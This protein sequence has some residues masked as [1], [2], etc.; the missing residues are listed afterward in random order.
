MPRSLF[1]IRTCLIL[2][3]VFSLQYIYA[4]S[5]DK[6][7]ILIISSYHSDTKYTYDNINDFINKYQRLGG[8]YAVGIENMYCTSLRDAATWKKALE[9]LLEKHSAPKLIILLGAEAWFS[10]FSLEEEKYKQ[11][12]VFCA[13]SY[14]YAACLEDCTL[15]TPAA[16]GT[17]DFLTL[18]EPFNV[19]A[20]YTYDY[21]VDLDIDLIRAFYPETKNIAFLS[22]NTYNGISHLRLMQSEMK[23]YPDLKLIPIDGR[24]ETLE[25][26]KEI[27]HNLPE[28]TVM[29]LGI[30]RIDKNDI[31]YMNNAVYS[32][33]SA[34]PDL[35]VFS[36]T[37]TGIGYWAIGG[38]VPVYEEIGEKLAV[39]A[40]RLLDQK[41]NE[42]KVVRI[43]D[44]EYK[45]DAKKLAEL[46][47]SKKMLPANSVLVNEEVSFWVRYR[48]PIIMVLLIIVLLSAGFITTFYYYLRVR[49]L[50]GHLAESEKQLR[51]DKEALEHSE[52]ELRIAKEKAEEANKMKSA[53]VSN[54]SHEIRTPLNAIVGFS[55]I[56]ASEVEGSDETKEYVRIIKQNSDL[57]LQLIN[58]IL[59]LSRLESGQIKLSLEKCDIIPYCRSIIKIV[60]QSKS[61]KV[62][63]LFS[64]PVEQLYLTT[65]TNRLQQII[66]N[67][68]T[69]AIKFTNDG[70]IELSVQLEK[71]SNRAIFS[72][73]DTGCGIPLE[74]QAKVFE[75]FVKVNEFIQGT[76]LGLSIC[77]LTVEKL[78]G[79]IWIDRSY[80]DGARFVFSHPIY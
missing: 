46:G 57:L 79:E 18:M 76:G 1:I 28:K 59:D 66:I 51:S 53:F 5:E 14:R 62:E 23:K 73:T 58:D 25:T 52:H 60:E 44:N 64:S 32:M 80:K 10:Y 16:E 30:W 43:N 8:A 71:E 31:V 20:C 40:Y 29:M 27:V 70:H 50:M 2:L 45:F 17:F 74:K 34:N 47:F 36:L 75:R 77:K 21:Q 69:N 22:D 56:L 11:I 42:K 61:P 4:E 13:M 38:C 78:G 65:D 54:M 49:L 35:P 7:E 19:K 33:T 55:S 26:A 67:L 6:K 39:H 37:S 41:V 15:V 48:W 63:I 12:P 9:N 72:V 68:L 3:C 24:K